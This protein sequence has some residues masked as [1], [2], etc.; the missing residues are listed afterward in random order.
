MAKSMQHWNGHQLCAIDTETTGTDPDL[1]EIIQICILALDS[2]IE[3]RKDVIPFYIEII[4]DHPERYD[5]GATRVTGLKLNDIMKRGHDSFAAIDLFMEWK[6]KLGLP[7]TKY[8]TPK[9][10]IPLAHNWPFDKGFIEKW[11]GASTYNEIF[12]A[13]FRDTLGIASFLN[14]RAG[15]HAEEVPYKKSKLGWMCTTNNIVN[16]NAHDALSDCVATAKLY[17]HLI[18]K[19]LF[20]GV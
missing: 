3:P 16:E 20:A 6:E 17:K 19:G 12:D 9:R 4:P 18:T 7:C 1:H 8:G 15:M 14:D 2:N 5:Q 13:H 10:I 11:L